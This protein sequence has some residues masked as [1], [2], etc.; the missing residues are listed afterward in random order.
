MLKFIAMIGKNL[1][2]L[3]NKNKISQQD[4]SSILQIP[5]TTL[6]DYERG[7]TEPNIAMLIKMS[8]HFDV[9][10]DELIAQDLSHSEYEVMK[11]KVM[12]I[13]AISVDDQNESQIDL[14]DSKAEAGYLDAYQNPEYIKELPKVH[15]PNIPKGTYRA[16]EIN[17]DSM[18]PIESGSI[19][20]AS[21]VENLNDIKN[22]RTY[23]VISKKEGLAYKRLKKDDDKNNLIL[24]SDNEVYYP[25]NLPYDDVDEVWQYYAHISFSDVKFDKDQMI[26]AKISDMHKKVSD[27]HS[28]YINLNK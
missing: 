27:I 24:I 8:K 10:V 18:L 15:L 1:K 2:Y 3:R 14:V 11:N 16:F 20:V 12:K 9:K 13:L 5:R 21:Y 22:D 6:G 26:Q 25:Y 23:I 7:K 17:G 4:L 28:R 19:I